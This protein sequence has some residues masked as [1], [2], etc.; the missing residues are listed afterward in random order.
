MGRRRF[1]LPWVRVDL[2]CLGLASI[3]F[4]LDKVLMH[5]HADKAMIARCWLAHARVINW[6]GEF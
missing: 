2:F 1:V 4:A 6:P 5:A 3:W